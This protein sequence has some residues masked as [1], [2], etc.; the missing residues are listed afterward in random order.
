MT[1]MQPWARR[2]DA[3]LLQME[4]ALLDA[5][6][7][8]LSAAVQTSEAGQRRTTAAET[9]QIHG[10]LLAAANAAAAAAAEAR[11]EA[12][13]LAQRQPNWLESVFSSAFEGFADNTSYLGRRFNSL[14]E[15][16]T[17]EEEAVARNLIEGPC[18]GFRVG[19]DS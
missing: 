11:A 9:R 6:H 17:K 16:E 10:S 14:A 18:L 1:V 15:K 19:F 13:E 7:A 3:R 2:L 4:A 8:M 12:N 5:Q